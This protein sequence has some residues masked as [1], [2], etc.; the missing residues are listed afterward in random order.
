MHERRLKWKTWEDFT[1]LRTYNLEVA[2]KEFRNFDANLFVNQ[3]YF[4][5]EKNQVVRKLIFFLVR[6]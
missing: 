1:Y 4:K 6:T 2:I 5:L 3:I